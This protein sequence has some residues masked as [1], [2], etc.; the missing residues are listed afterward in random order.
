MKWYVLQVMTGKETEVRDTLQKER[1][2]AKVPQ[3]ITFIRKGGQWTERLSV[4]IPGYVFVGSDDFSSTEYYAGK[5]MPGAIR[6]LG[7][8]KPQSISYIEAEYIGLLAPSNDPLQPSTVTVQDDVFEVEG[9]LAHLPARSIKYNI[10]QRRARVN[11]T[12]LGEERTVD[13]AIKL[14]GT[15]EE[16]EET[17]DTD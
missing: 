4:L 6:W 7:A 1:I 10:R 15:A 13:F 9:V 5:R 14:A 17:P 3:E 11:M 12:I 16:C 8:Q 2:P